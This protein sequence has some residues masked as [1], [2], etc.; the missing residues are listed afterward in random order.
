MKLQAEFVKYLMS[1]ALEEADKAAKAGEVPIGA[2]IARNE[3]IVARAHNEME[4]LSDASAHA[5]ILA[6]RHA[7]KSKGDWR[8]R[9]HT[10]CVTVEPCTMCIGALRLARIGTIIFGAR[11]PRLGAVGSLYDLAIDERLGNV[12]RVI[13]GVEEEECRE[14]LE[15]FFRERRDER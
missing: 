3:T 12:P 4:L 1:A 2:V 15:R 6:L 11:D 13:G 9:D 8:L 10:I 14:R 7:G 5:E